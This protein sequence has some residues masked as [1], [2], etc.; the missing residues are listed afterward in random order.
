MNLLNNF[1]RFPPDGCTTAI[2]VL[3]SQ[4]TTDCELF[5]GLRTAVPVQMTRPLPTALLI[6]TEEMRRDE[7]K[8]GKKKNIH[9]ETWFGFF[10]VD[11]LCNPLLA[12]STLFQQAT[13]FIQPVAESFL[14]C[15]LFFDRL[16]EPCFSF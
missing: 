5:L 8:R 15:V 14:N 12:I 10:S 13:V 2:G 1:G 11:P 3:C 9:P 7:G 6:D 16:P 4:W